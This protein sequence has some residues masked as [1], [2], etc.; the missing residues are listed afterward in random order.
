MSLLTPFR[1]LGR[2]IW[3]AVN[4]GFAV[5]FGYQVLLSTK[6]TASLRKNA[7]LATALLE[8]TNVLEKLNAWAGRQAKRESREAQKALDPEP[9][10]PALPPTLPTNAE[11]KRELRRLVRERRG[12]LTRL[13]VRAIP[14]AAAPLALQPDAG[15]GDDHEPSD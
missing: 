13:D 15:N 3:D 5:L 8:V 9:T 11:R 1:T 10:Q 7:E 14:A 2:R 6:P 4:A 12:G